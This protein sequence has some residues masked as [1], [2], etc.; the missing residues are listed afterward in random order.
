MTLHDNL[1]KF[2]RSLSY[3]KKEHVSK[4]YYLK[5]DGPFALFHAT[6]GSLLS[7]INIVLSENMIKLKP[8]PA[9]PVM[10]TLCPE[11]ISSKA[12][13]CFGVNN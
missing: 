13:C 10:K 1:Q 8:V 7:S 4:F 12:S 3:T 2:N 5:F 9:W 6:E 11:Q